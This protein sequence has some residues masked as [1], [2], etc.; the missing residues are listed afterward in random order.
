[1]LHNNDI[2]TGDF[3]EYVFFLNK[4]NQFY[5]QKLHL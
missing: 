5:F 3:N 4:K 1:M 2:I